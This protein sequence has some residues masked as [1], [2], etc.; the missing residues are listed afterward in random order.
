MISLTA[1]NQISVSPV[2]SSGPGAP[3]VY[4]FVVADPKISDCL[5]KMKP[6]APAVTARPMTLV[7]AIKSTS[8][9]TQSQPKL[10]SQTTSSKE[11]MSSHLKR[12]DPSS[13]DVNQQLAQIGIDAIA[14]QA[15]VSD[16]FILIPLSQDHF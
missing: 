9:I 8:S 12:V 15:Q 6:N 1:K 7:H 4:R 2:S 16:L 10:T 13:N 5:T 3:K 11:V 14:A